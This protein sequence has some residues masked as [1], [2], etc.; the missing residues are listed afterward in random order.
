MFAQLRGVPEVPRW[1]NAP[2]LNSFR[3]RKIIVGTGANGGTNALPKRVRQ[4]AD[5]EEKH[6][7][8]PATGPGK[9]AIE[10]RN[11]KSMINKCLIIV[12]TVAGG[13]SAAARA[14]RWRED[15]EIIRLEPGP[16][17]SFANCGLPYFVGGEIAEHDSLAKRPAPM[18]FSMTTIPN[19]IIQI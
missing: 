15:C 1:G 13:A 8:R 14:R 11:L 9:D 4:D 10:W 19:Q 6:Q 16:H 3:Q 2:Y 17:V 18:S 5:G 12:G 7:Q